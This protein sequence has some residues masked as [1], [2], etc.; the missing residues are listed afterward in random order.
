M[1]TIPDEPL[2][3]VGI[4]T[5]QHIVLARY[6]NHTEIRD[7]VIGK[8]FHWEQKETQRFEGE[9]QLI[10][11]EQG[12][13]T[14][15]NIVSLERYLRSVISSE[16]N[17]ASPLELLKAHAIIARSWA[18]AQLER[19]PHQEFDVCADD[20]CQRYQGIE[21]VASLSA[22]EAVEETRGQVL[23][24]EDVLCD[25]RYSKC[26]GGAL[27]QFS[28]CW[29]DTDMPYLVGKRDS[30]IQPNNLTDVPL[31]TEAGARA[32]ITASP[33]AYCNVKDKAVLR[34]V[35]NNYD[36]ETVDFYRWTVRYTQGE[37]TKLVHRFHPELGKIQNLIPLKRGVSG[38]IYHLR[39]EGTRGCVEV[40]KELTIR[41][42]LSPS[43]LYSS[44]FTVDREEA[45]FILHGA[46]WGHGVGLCQIG[47]ANMAHKGMDY[48]TILQHY[49]PNTT[50]KTLDYAK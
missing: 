33:P 26:C 30:E 25:A 7:V 24:C 41:K 31:H 36:Q 6:D 14:A 11:A 37:L 34:Q 12:M 1:R 19:P 39:V 43:H 18:L 23:C 40:G 47:A 27:E 29:E 35:L 44:A 15:V 22:R 48:K 49:Y 21:R 9:M 5:A 17:A 38:R 2:I 32:W 4:L 13:Q 10:A 3:R 46:G 8:G 45:D 20:H 42:L 28:T 50:L 16:M